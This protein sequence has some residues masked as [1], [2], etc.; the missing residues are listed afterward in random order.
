MTVL[1][2]TYEIPCRV[3]GNTDCIELPADKVR[4]IYL[5]GGQQII[6]ERDDGKR[7]RV[8]SGKPIAVE[9]R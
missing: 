3:F 8:R 9:Q 1:R 6:V 2:F 7:F 5:E 4:W